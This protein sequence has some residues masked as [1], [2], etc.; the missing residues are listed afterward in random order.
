[1]YGHATGAATQVCYIE[2]Q[3]P[4]R[5]TRIVTT[6]SLGGFSGGGVHNDLTGR[7]ASDC[8]PISAITGLSMAACGRYDAILGTGI[9]S[10]LT[11]DVFPPEAQPPL[12]SGA[13][14]SG[15]GVVAIT[16]GTFDTDETLTIRWPAGL[17]N[18]RVQC[19]ATSLASASYVRA[20]LYRVDTGTP[21]TIGWTHDFRVASTDMANGSVVVFGIVLPELV[22]AGATRP[23]LRLVLQAKTDSGSAV[24]VYVGAA[25]VETPLMIRQPYPTLSQLGGVPTTRTINGQDLTADRTIPTAGR[26]VARTIY[27]SGSASTH[28]FTAGIGAVEIFGVAK[29]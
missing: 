7:S 24:H 23:L 1:M 19:A 15:S 4:F 22:D 2:W 20:T 21:T 6:L 8:H 25:T 9:L 13:I 29:G 26:L 14:T 5:D 3:N 12:D 28:T 17:W 18:L 11:D 27:T 16:G 10:E